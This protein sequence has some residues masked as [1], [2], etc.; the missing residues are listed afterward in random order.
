MEN[1][2]PSHQDVLQLIHE[3]QDSFRLLI[4]YLGQVDTKA[5]FLLL[6]WPDVFSAYFEDNIPQFTKDINQLICL[7]IKVLVESLI[8]YVEKEA[9][10]KKTT[11]PN[12][13]E[14]IKLA[15]FRYTQ[16]DKK[17]LIALC[18]LQ[19]ERLKSFDIDIES[20]KENTCSK[21]S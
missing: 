16:N 4:K 2:K 6:K 5:N 21:S 18:N 14:E 11:I 3:A 1:T 13:K 9:K 15:Q 10:A 8:A 17:A 19:I 20:I 12:L 7:P